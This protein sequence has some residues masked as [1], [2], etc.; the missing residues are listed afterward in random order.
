MIEQIF[1]KFVWP[2]ALILGLVYNPAYIQLGSENLIFDYETGDNT[3]LYY[4]SIKNIGGQKARFDVSANVPWIFVNQEGY[5]N[6]K[7]I[8]LEREYT[9]NFVLNIRQEM[10]KN[11]KH[12]DEVTVEAINLGDQS[13]LDYK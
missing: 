2:F 3:P 10:V 11:G 8:Q 5:D 12:F 6:V 13:V 4:L 9:V 1:S 7:N